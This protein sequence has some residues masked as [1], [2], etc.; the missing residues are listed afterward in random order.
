MDWLL[1]LAQAVTLGANNYGHDAPM[2]APRAAPTF[3]EEFEGRQVD[4]ETWR[5][6]T[7]RNAVGWHNN[8]RQYYSRAIAKNARIERGALVLEAHRET[9]SL[10]ATAFTRSEPGCRA[11]A[12]SGRRSGCCPRRANGPT[13]ARS[14][15]WRWSAGMRT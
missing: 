7:E 2:A 14:T 5:Y 6:G 12:G 10:M 9:L 4:R 3:A 8:E 11:G 15:S 1:L 13:P